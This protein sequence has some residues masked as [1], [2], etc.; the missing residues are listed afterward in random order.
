MTPT[1]TVNQCR[2]SATPTAGQLNVMGANA[3]NANRCTATMNPITG[4]SGTGISGFPTFAFMLY[5]E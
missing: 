1:P 4:Q 2:K 3:D 5:S